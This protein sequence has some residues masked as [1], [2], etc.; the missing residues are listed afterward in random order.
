MK[1]K[2]VM[3][4]FLKIFIL[5]MNISCA[6][7]EYESGIGMEAPGGRAW[8][9][10]DPRNSI[11]GEGSTRLE[12]FTDELRWG[13]KVNHENFRRN[14]AFAPL[15]IPLIPWLS[16]ISDVREHSFLL[17]SS[18]EVVIDMWFSPRWH[19]TQALRAKAF[20]PNGIFLKMKN[21]K[22]VYPTRIEARSRIKGMITANTD[23]TIHWIGISGPV[24]L[25][26]YIAFQLIFDI[27]YSE[28]LDSKLIIDVLEENGKKSEG[29]KRIIKIQ[30]SEGY[31]YGDIAINC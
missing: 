17:S 6:M 21:A 5:L 26:D 7:L 18:K 22:N 12:F 27:S 11:S 9:S 24:P 8:R 31:W 4:N 13:L 1:F 28:I 14:V 2:N 3:H 16:G 19:G 29:F 25:E 30:R 23:Q 10:C 15:F 20:N